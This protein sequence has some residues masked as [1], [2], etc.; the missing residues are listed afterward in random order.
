M[1]T[2]LCFLTFLL[3]HSV[4]GAWSAESK[5]IDVSKLPPPAQRSGV[6]FAKDIKPIFEQACFACHADQR[7]KAGLRLDQLEAVLKGTKGG[8]VIEPGKA[9]KSLLLAT[10]ARLDRSPAMPPKGKGN[11]LTRD[12]VALIRAWIEQGAK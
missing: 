10:V 2:R 1:K 6:N 12:Q 5:T 7:Q 3:A 11:P 9:E 8:K 4:V